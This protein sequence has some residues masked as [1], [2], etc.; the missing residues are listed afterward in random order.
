V[1][2]SRWAAVKI[3]GFCGTDFGRD[4]E[5]RRREGFLDILGIKKALAG[6]PAPSISLY[7][8]SIAFWVRQ[9]GLAFGFIFPLFCTGCF[10]FLVL[11]LLT[12]FYG[13]RG[14]VGA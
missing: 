4:A 11:Y 6:E 13:R 1:T 5:G 8:F 9:G 3:G 2:S 14:C 10:D 7:T 12:A